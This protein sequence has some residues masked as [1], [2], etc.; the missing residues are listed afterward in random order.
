[1]ERYIVMRFLAG[2]FLLFVVMFTIIKIAGG[3]DNAKKPYDATDQP[4]VLID[5]VN[6]SSSVQ[7]EIRGNIVA[8]ENF[9]KIRFTIS[10]NR[11]LVQLLNGYDEE[12]VKSISLIND[13]D[14]YEQFIY[15]LDNNGFLNELKKQ[16]V[17]DDRGICYNGREYL[18]KLRKEGK[19][20]KKLWST[21]CGSKIGTSNANRDDIN[22]LFELQ[23]PE[24]RQFASDI[25][26]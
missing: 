6:K 15:A 11:R 9:N 25:T 2:V 17:T 16:T 12:I 23:F 22:E 18:F 3:N 21:S 20:V 4:I 1:M 8:K 7:F 24:Y 14:A 5:Q 26:I 19:V 13:I 10:K